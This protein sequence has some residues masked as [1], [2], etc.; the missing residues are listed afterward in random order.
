LTI[1]RRPRSIKPSRLRQL[2]MSMVEILLV[3][4]SVLGVSVLAFQA[5]QS[6][7]LAGNVQVEQQRAK[8]LIDTIDSAYGSVGSIGTL[9][10]YGLISAGLAPAPMISGTSLVHSFGGTVVVAPSATGYTITYNNMP[11]DACNS[12]TTATAGLAADVT[13]NNTDVFVS[14]VLDPATLVASC[15]S[16][17]NAVVLN[18]IAATSQQSAGAL[19]VPSST[20]FALIPGC[21]GAGCPV[22]IA[23]PSVSPPVVALPASPS[24]PAPRGIVAAGSSGPTCAT[25]TTQTQTIACPLGQTGNHIQIQTRACGGAWG[26][27]TDYYNGCQAVPVNGIVTPP[28]ASGCPLCANGQYIQNQNYKPAYP[29]TWSCGNAPA[30]WESSC[31]AVCVV[32]A[33]T[34]APQSQNYPCPG[35]QLVTDPGAYQYTSFG[36]QTRTATTTYY[37]PLYTGSASAN[38]ATYS[39]WSP[40]AYNC[41]PACVAPANSTNT[42][43]Q[44][45]TCPAGKF[46]TDPGPYFGLASGPQTRTST[47]SWTCSTPTAAPTS[48]TSAWST[49][50]PVYTCANPCVHT[51]SPA[52]SQ[53]ATCGA[54]F[55]GSWAQTQSCTESACPV[56][57]GNTTWSCTGWA[58]AVAP[59]GACV[60]N[61]VVPPNSTS[62]QNQNYNCLG[63]DL[64]ADPGAYQYTS[65]G[66]QTHTGTTTYYCPTATGSPAANPTTYGAW[67]PAAYTCSAACVAPANTTN[68]GNNTFTCPSGQLITNPG[69]YQYQAS[70]QQTHTS[71]TSWSCATPISSPTS[72]TSAWSTWSPAYT[73][74]NACVAPG[75]VT[76]TGNQTFTCPAGKWITDAGASQ[77]QSSGPQTRTSTTTSSCSTPTSTV[78]TSTSAWSVWSPA[79]TCANTVPCTHP[80]SPATSQAGACA[81]G[82]TSSWT[83]TK[84]CA[85]SACPAGGGSTTWSC[86]GWAPATAPAGGC[87]ALTPGYRHAFSS[88]AI[89][90]SCSGASR[91]NE[92]WGWTYYGSS[93]SNGSGSCTE[94]GAYNVA[95]T[96]NASFL[97]FT[98]ASWSGLTMGYGALIPNHVAYPAGV[99]CYIGESADWSNCDGGPSGGAIN[100]SDNWYCDGTP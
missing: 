81:A 63:T 17:G 94:S 38:P 54:G 62:T 75:P 84:T 95:C 58:P 40:A 43:N 48:V 6:S 36:V 9:S 33:A 67:S 77:Y 74:A 86:S 87:T 99:A 82:Y 26:P 92:S 12:F 20:P 30:A 3:V 90:S 61:C 97:S 76:N 52:T 91:Y 71:T 39:A 28:A 15:V 49:W 1:N 21:S 80:A 25:T 66:V 68:S 13:V 88:S 73:C 46:I 35:T 44:T 96:G 64:I 14:G 83:Q 19:G 34:T 4:G 2:G 53:T 93:S 32:P 31:P 24:N 57:G 23:P 72:T 7:A 10:T 100:Q 85:E 8:A 60:G 47:T 37:C 29:A 18:F 78:S 89:D 51:A 70:G 45:F 69:A 50:S 55:T 41:A 59:A 98:S 56:G 42:G 5:N 16:S 65:F 22:Q 79:Y 11:Q 27:W